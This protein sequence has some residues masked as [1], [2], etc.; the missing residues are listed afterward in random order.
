MDDNWR[1]TI[2]FSIT[3]IRTSKTLRPPTYVSTALAAVGRWL[4]GPLPLPIGVLQALNV[5]VSW[6]IIAGLFAVM[7]KVLPNTDVHWR[8]VWVGAGVTSFLF[9]IGKS[10]LS[11]YIAKA[12]VGSSYGSAGAVMVLLLWVYYSGLI[13]YFGAEFTK[14]YADEYGSPVAPRRFAQP[15][16]GAGPVGGGLTETQVM[17]DYCARPNQ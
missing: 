16:G 1:K 13:V 17:L 8:D 14:V 5:L 7:F 2:N 3:S 12:A 6:V 10:L 11:V 15:H 9:S 4:S